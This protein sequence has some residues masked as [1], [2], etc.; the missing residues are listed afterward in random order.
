[1][2][3]DDAEG[4]FMSPDVMCLRAAMMAN[5]AQIVDLTRDNDAKLMLLSAMECLLFTINP[6]RGQVQEI[7]H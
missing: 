3:E 4:V 5:L 7:H 6:P 2:D 1:M